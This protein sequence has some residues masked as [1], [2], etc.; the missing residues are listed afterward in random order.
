MDWNRPNVLKAFNRLTVLSEN[1]SAGVK[2]TVQY[3]IDDD[4]SFTLINTS[5]SVF[6]VSPSET[7]SFNT[8]VTGRRIRLKLTGQATASSTPILKGFFLE[9]SWRPG[10]LKRWQV[11]CDLEDGQLNLMGVPT[12]LTAQVTLASLKTLEAE[13]SPLK[14]DDIDGTANNVHITNMGERMI[15]PVLVEAGQGGKARY[16]RVIDLELTEAF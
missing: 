13:T 12:A 9:A 7:I 5:S 6:D 4:V 16:K 3:E 14:F 1:L 11:T 15:V 2:W 10:R 8:G